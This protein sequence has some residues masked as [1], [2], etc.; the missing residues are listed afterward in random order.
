MTRKILLV[1]DDEDIRLVAGV[2]LRRIAG[3]EVVEAES[4][5]EA[6]TRIA[7]DRPDVVLLDVMMP[8]VDGPAT[9]AR[10]RSDATTADLPVIFLTAKAQKSELESYL[11]LGANGV[12]PKPFD[13]TTLPDEIQ[14]VVDGRRPEVHADD[15]LAPLRE[16]YRRRLP[17]LVAEL[18]A[19]LSDTVPPARK[20]IEAARELAHRLKGTTGSYGFDEV[21]AE[22]AQIEAGL[23]GLLA[24]SGGDLAMTWH[25]ISAALR[26]ARTAAITP[27]PGAVNRDG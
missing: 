21:S 12:I 14:R 5:D 22:L 24:R 15:S 4:G 19:S 17:E 27:R 1:D 9:L 2:A 10:I 23:D 8:N 20:R 13:V 26:R 3:W 6:L 18:G 25:E 16:S 11:A 7:E